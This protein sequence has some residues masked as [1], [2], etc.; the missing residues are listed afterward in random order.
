MIR[1]NVINYKLLGLDYEY[2]KRYL[3]FNP[4]PFELLGQ[5]IQPYS[6]LDINEIDQKC[7]KLTSLDDNIDLA[8]MQDLSFSHLHCHSSYS[9]LQASCDIATSL[10]K[11][12]F[13]RCLL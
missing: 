9:V 12:N 4:K 8:E 1:L 7:E 5:N 2:N 6:T 11:Q 3:E 13:S 10:Q